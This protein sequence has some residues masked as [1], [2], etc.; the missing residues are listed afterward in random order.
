MS[1]YGVILDESCDIS[2]D[3]KLGIDLRYVSYQSNDV[4]TK[5]LCNASISD[6][7]AETIK[8]EIIKAIRSVGSACADLVG[9][10][11]E[12]ASVMTG[13]SNGVGAKLKQEAPALVHIHCL[14]HRVSLAS[15]D[16]AAA[17]PFL[18]EVK[19]TLLSLYN[20]FKYSAIWY[21][22][23]KELQKVFDEPSLKLKE[24]TQI[25]WLSVHCAISTVCI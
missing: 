10:G 23:L 12:G 18:Q 24:A 7:Q 14:A 17:F 22:K 13:R 8:N 19:G 9:L 3:K 5:F 4:V 11:S 15:C 25:R 20:Y 16:A 6:G 21:S 1:Y 2:V